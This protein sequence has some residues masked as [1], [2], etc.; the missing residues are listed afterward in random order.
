MWL[1]LIAFGEHLTPEFSLSF[2][3]HVHLQHPQHAVARYFTTSSCSV[4]TIFCHLLQT[5]WFHF[6]A[7]SSCTGTAD[8]N[9]LRII[10]RINLIYFFPTDFPLEGACFSP[11]S[12]KGWEK[13]RCFKSASWDGYAS[14]RLCFLGGMGISWLGIK[15]RDEILCEIMLP[16]FL[17]LWAWL[18]L[19]SNPCNCEVLHREVATSS[20]VSCHT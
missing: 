19:I 16:F 2:L 9:L 13:T 3:N 20:P 14:W 11:V 5:S 1:Y 12:S 10:L 7:H 6:I 15:F 8:E 18:H 4:E 17:T